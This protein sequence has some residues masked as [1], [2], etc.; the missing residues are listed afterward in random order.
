MCRDCGI[1]G[2]V[3]VRS[4][5]FADWTRREPSRGVRNAHVEFTLDA[6][7][8]FFADNHATLHNRRAFVDS[9]HADERRCLVRL[10][11]A[12]EPRN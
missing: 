10:W 6:R 7:D 3:R 9:R 12:G 1:G 11:L 5:K 4:T 8:V 2:K